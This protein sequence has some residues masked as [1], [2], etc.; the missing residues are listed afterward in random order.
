MRESNA[1]VTN[2]QTDLWEPCVSL[3]AF[4]GAHSVCTGSEEAKA[5]I[6]KQAWYKDASATAGGHAT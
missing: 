1:L 4:P 2:N 6:K 3:S 5:L